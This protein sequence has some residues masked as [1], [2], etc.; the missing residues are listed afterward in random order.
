MRKGVR[1]TERLSLE[2]G[3]GE[4]T[5]EKQKG[6]KILLLEGGKGKEHV[7]NQ[8]GVRNLPLEGGSGNQ[9]VRNKREGNQ[10]VVTVG[11]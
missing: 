4:G 1:K 6:M 9:N 10:E 2:G 7:R 5:H 3:E 11:F 8:R